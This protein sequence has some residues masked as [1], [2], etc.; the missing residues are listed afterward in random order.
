MSSNASKKELKFIR[1]DFQVQADGQLVQVL[2][3]REN[4]ITY[5]ELYYKGHSVAIVPIPVFTFA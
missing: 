2:D 3:T 4:A 1:Q 5:A